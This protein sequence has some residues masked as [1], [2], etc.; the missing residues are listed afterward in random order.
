MDR[1]IQV[2]EDNSSPSI[3]VSEEFESNSQLMAEIS[4]S[5]NDESEIASLT[6]DGYEISLNNSKLKFSY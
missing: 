3:I 1:N 2:T 5:I 4:G 6:I